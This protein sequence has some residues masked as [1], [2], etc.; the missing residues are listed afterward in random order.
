MSVRNFAFFALAASAAVIPSIA[1][2]KEGYPP[3]ILGTNLVAYKQDNVD[4]AS[5]KFRLR[6][7]QI[8]FQDQPLAASPTMDLFNDH[9]GLG[10]S[11]LPSHSSD[12]AE[13][14]EAAE[15]ADSDDSDS[16]VDD[17]AS[18]AAQQLS[19]SGDQVT[20]SLAGSDREHD[21][22][23]HFSAFSGDDSE[24]A[25]GTIDDVGKQVEDLA[26]G[27]SGIA[28]RSPRSRGRPDRFEPL[29]F[30]TNDSENIASYDLYD[31][32]RAAEK[33]AKDTTSVASDIV[34]RSHAASN[35]GTGAVG[36][37]TVSH[38][39]S[40]GDSFHSAGGDFS[41]AASIVTSEA[42]ESLSEII[43]PAKR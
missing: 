18:Q 7:R 9:D 1:S 23:S 32:E 25:D 4:P 15:P 29:D 13:P 39:D 35:T 21:S 43:S 2:V 33:A 31:I 16:A 11:V 27:V 14:T 22:T 19:H 5:S 42:H 41:S 30:I 8:A 10:E 38:D 34:S 40:D 17:V 20:D 28:S 36:V 37:N 24:D 6:A 12:V 3:A 26:S